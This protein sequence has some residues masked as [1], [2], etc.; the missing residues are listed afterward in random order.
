MF[1][2]R[3]IGVALLGLLASAAQAQTGEPVRPS[4]DSGAPL[5]IPVAP[6]AQLPPAERPAHD[7]NHIDTP[8][9]TLEKAGETVKDLATGDIKALRRGPLLIHGNYC[10]IGNRPGTS[11]VDVLDAACQRHDACTHTGSLPSCA[12]D[13]R[14]LHEASAIAEDSAR[15]DELRALAASMAASMA[16]LV[17]K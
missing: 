7:A 9:T 11:P 2:G 16:V 13:E 3:L 15:P 17:C 5:T 10:G 14:F 6:S 8:A 1:C 4:P 12:C